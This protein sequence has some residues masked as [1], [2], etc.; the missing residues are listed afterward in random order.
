MTA[1]GQVLGVA[2]LGG[3]A[4]LARFRLDGAVSR[5]LGGGFP[6]GTLVVNGVGALLAGLVAGV[7][8]DEGVR[9]L[10]AIGMLGSFSTFSTWMLETQRLAEDSRPWVAAANVAIPVAVGIAA[11]AIG[12]A[13]GA[14]L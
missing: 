13:I 1:L 4:A 9:V 6:W 3:F 10:L 11:V 2:V 8:P 7:A 12:W 5:R 14:R